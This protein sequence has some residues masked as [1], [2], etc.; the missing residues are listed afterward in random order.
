MHLLKKYN[1]IDSGNCIPNGQNNILL[2]D[3]EVK[4][5]FNALQ[6]NCCQI[7]SHDLKFNSF[8]LLRKHMRGTHMLLSCELC[9]ANLKVHF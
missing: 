7:C 5:A 8:E 2:C 1:D 6:E 9:V 4:D 3:N